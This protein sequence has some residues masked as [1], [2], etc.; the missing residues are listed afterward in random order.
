MH[1]AKSVREKKLETFGLSFNDFFS[2]VIDNWP[3][4]DK[5]FTNY[6]DDNDCEALLEDDESEFTLE[7]AVKDN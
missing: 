5:A 3:K 4:V 2:I 6:Q 1:N 7:R